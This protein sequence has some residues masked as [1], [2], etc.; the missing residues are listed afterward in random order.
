MS[1]ILGEQRI[2][3]TWISA[4][5]HLKQNKDR[6]RNVMLEL[7]QPNVVTQHDKDCIGL[8]DT[9]LRDHCDLS[10]QTVAGTIFPHGL[11][12]RAGAAQLESRYFKVMDR[13]KKK[14]TWGTYAMRLM[15][16]PDK[17]GNPFNPLERVIKKLKHAAG[18]GNAFA[19]NYE[20]GVHAPEDLTLDEPPF[21]EVPLYSPGRDSKV[22]QNYPCLSHL[23]FKLVDGSVDLTAIYRSH[24]YAER[25]LGNLIGLSHLMDFVAT[26]S[27]LKVGRLTCI[28]TDATLDWH[29]W[30]GVAK[31]KALMAKF[32]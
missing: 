1:V 21:C 23:T 13:A 31:G 5:E 30:G 20:L 17:D 3:P 7:D 24:W 32:A 11:Y 28:S 12:K 2:V 26:E 8:V 22:I 6:A 29:S 19:S 9:A 10:I 4:L 27:G 14:G 16:R 15:R 18:P 25:A